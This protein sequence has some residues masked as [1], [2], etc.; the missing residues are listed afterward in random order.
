MPES[1][2]TSCYVIEPYRGKRRGLIF[3]K[4]LK[5]YYMNRCW[6][7]LPQVRTGWQEFSQSAP[8]LSW[9]VIIA[10]GQMYL[11]LE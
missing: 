4:D 3:V 1:V 10:S 9:R 5:K 8:E 6:G 11:V 7:L 2:N